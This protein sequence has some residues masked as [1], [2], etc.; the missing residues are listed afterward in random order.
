MNLKLITGAIL[1]IIAFIFTFI[2]FI[3]LKPITNLQTLEEKTE[4]L[5]YLYKVTEKLENSNEGKKYMVSSD[6]EISLQDFEDKNLTVEYIDS[7][8]IWNPTLCAK[9]PTAIDSKG[10]VFMLDVVYKEG[11]FIQRFI[12]YNLE[13]NTKKYFDVSDKK[14][15]SDLL[16]ENDI[17]HFYEKISFLNYEYFFKNTLVN[18]NKLQRQ[19]DD[20]YVNKREEGNIVEVSMPSEYPRSFVLN[21]KDVVSYTINS[22]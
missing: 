12:I 5:G 8:Y 15:A 17:P 3:F 22:F 16:L 7:S 21:N 9:M 13:Q 20:S 4:N 11:K 18:M 2:Y 1:F 19:K 10:N 6:R 14:I